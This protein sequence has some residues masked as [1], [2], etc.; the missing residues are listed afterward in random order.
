MADGS[1]SP[2]DS[3]TNKKKYKVRKPDNRDRSE[4]YMTKYYKEP[5]NQKNLRERI[6]RYK[7]A[8]ADLQGKISKLEK[9]VF[10]I[11]PVENVR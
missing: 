11:S 7:E 10:E 6:A 8:M 2:V 9:F 1:D 4:E 3:T 5:E